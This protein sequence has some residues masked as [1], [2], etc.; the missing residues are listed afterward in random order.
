MKIETGVQDVLNEIEFELAQGTVSRDDLGKA[1]QQVRQFHGKLRAEI[2]GTPA[3][4]LDLREIVNRQFQLNDMMLTLVQEMSAALHDT[5]LRIART[6]TLAPSNETT[7]AQTI[8]A[9]DAMAIPDDDTPPPW[10]DDAVR[11][12]NAATHDALAQ[13]VDA[14]PV[15][16][17]VIGGV[18][19]R[20]RAALHDVILFYVNRLAQRQATINNVY[21]EQLLTLKRKCEVQEEQI[22]ALTQGLKT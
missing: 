2:Y 3:Q 22:R 11:A 19:S 15:G 9:V 6:H 18:L 7:T 4:S 17:P 13:K 14:R 5:Q 21:G 12:L 10:D 20:I 1:V 8:H 16:I